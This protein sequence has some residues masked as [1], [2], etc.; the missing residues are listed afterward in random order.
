MLLLALTLRQERT[1]TNKIYSELKNSM[2]RMKTTKFK[3]NQKLFLIWIYY[4]K[5]VFFMV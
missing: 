4:D 1:M 3:I 5:D 2:T